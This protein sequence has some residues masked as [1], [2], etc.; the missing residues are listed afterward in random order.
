MLKIDGFDD[1]VV[2]VVERINTPPIICYDQKKI[3]SKLIRDAY[4]SWDEAH[5]HF[6]YN[7]KEA[8]VG[9]DTPC[10]LTHESLES[11]N[12]NTI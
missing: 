1:C 8:Y 6:E 10:F 11:F 2:G 9:E 7:M 4:F 5:E 12:N 3:I